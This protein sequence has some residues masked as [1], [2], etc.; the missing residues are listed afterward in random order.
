MYQD[1]L[2]LFLKKAT[3][4]RNVGSKYKIKSLPNKV[5]VSCGCDLSTST[6]KML[7]F[8]LIFVCL[9]NCAT[10]TY[11]AVGNR[12]FIPTSSTTVVSRPYSHMGK[13][14]FLPPSEIFNSMYTY[15]H[16]WPTLLRR[17]YYLLRLQ[18]R[19]FKSP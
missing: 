16:I 13:I 15:V 4:G 9:A 19:G 1:C 14:M 11:V 17:W 7:L 5:D 18:L 3:S 2:L 12:R 8:S 6:I 10:R